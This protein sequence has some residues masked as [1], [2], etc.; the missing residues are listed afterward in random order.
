M[1]LPMTVDELTEEWVSGALREH[2]PAVEPEGVEIDQVI[3]GTATK[4]LLSVAYAEGSAADGPPQRLCVKGALDEKMRQYGIGGACLLEAAFYKHI[5]DGLA[6]PMARHWYAEYSETPRQ[7]IVI[8]D[9]IGAGGGSFGRPTEPWPVDRV[10]AAL[11]L[12]ASWHGAT[13]GM[14]A[15]RYPWMGVGS[16]SVRS[17]T[18][19]ILGEE[20]WDAHFSAS[21]APSLPDSLRDRAR[22]LEALKAMWRDDDTRPMALSHYD[23]H[24]GNT[25]IDADG[26]PGFLDWQGVCVAPYIDDVTYFIGGALTVEDRRASERDL[27]AEYLRALAA[28]GGP[29]LELDAVWPE[30]QRHHLHG[31][32]WAVTPPVM[33]SPENVAAMTARYVAALE[34]HDSLGVGAAT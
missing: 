17:V 28:A 25:F 26:R 19:V 8:L 27:L 10:A 9:D 34:D 20:H 1:D 15:S 21:Y 5:A 6:R 14:D 3:W 32:L 12:L 7:G 24:L 23:P 30:Y 31:F 29:A 18:D 22:I 16:S 33:Q 4:V 13:W 2:N 11:E